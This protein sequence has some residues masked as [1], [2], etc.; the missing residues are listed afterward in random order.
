MII[1]YSERRIPLYIQF[2]PS[3]YEID[4]INFIYN[5][6]NFN[7]KL[8]NNYCH[9]ILNIVILIAELYINYHTF[10]QLFQY[11]KPLNLASLHNTICRFCIY[12]ELSSY[13]LRFDKMINSNVSSQSIHALP[14]Y[15]VLLKFSILNG[16]HI[17][18]C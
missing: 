7:T 16:F 14:Q 5:K 4:R 17:D 18:F 15:I 13:I 11:N 3:A 9:S 8:K 12:I 1:K 10:L 6:L 2:L